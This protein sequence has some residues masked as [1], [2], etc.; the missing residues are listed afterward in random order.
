M[1]AASRPEPKARPPAP[2][3]RCVCT[4]VRQVARRVSAL[5]D[6]E[7]AGF[8]LSVTNYALLARIERADG[9]GMSDLAGQMV[10]DRTTLT[11]NLQ[12]LLRDR[13]VRAE[14]ESDRRR[15]SL[16]ITAAGRQL[17][18]RSHASWKRAQRMLEQRLGPDRT[19]AL[20]E[21]IDA[22]LVA[23]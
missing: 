21:L 17:L 15:R 20:L 2:P 1:R 16:R 22:A 8:G 23:V 13:L 18:K 10:M 4:A 5:Y 14:A 9:I 3:E 6:G 11:R 12:P 19:A 7:L